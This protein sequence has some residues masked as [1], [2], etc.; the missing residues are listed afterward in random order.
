MLMHPQSKYPKVVAFA[1]DHPLP[2]KADAMADALL[3][4]ACI[5]M[6]C[7]KSESASWDSLRLEIIHHG[8]ASEHPGAFLSNPALLPN[9]S[10]T[11]KDGYKSFGSHTAGG[12]F[13][14]AHYQEDSLGT[15]LL[16]SAFSPRTQKPARAASLYA[17]SM[18]L[19]I[20][21]GDIAKASAHA[22][23]GIS[24]DDIAR[25]VALT[26]NTSVFFSIEFDKTQ[27]SKLGALRLDA[28]ADCIDFALSDDKQGL[29][30]TS[31]RDDLGKIS[32]AR[33]SLQEARTIEQAC[34]AG[35]P[36]APSPRV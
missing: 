30:S 27:L 22:S 1:K 14:Y 19:M 18:L 16:M 28:S 8:Y 3:D 29:F 31:P 26:P 24:M 12:F 25:G 9:T 23:D 5:F 11:T 34:Q 36:R 10:S 32:A 21:R 4:L 13:S 2:K 6:A 7:K 15:A 35:R 17:K 20:E 33:R